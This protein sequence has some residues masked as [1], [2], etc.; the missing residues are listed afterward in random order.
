[1]STEKLF[2]FSKSSET[3]NAS[4]GQLGPYMSAVSFF[5]VIWVL[6][7][8]IINICILFF[9]GCH[10]Q[11]TTTQPWESW[12][13]IWS[14]KIIFHRP[15][16]IY[17]AGSIVSWH[18]NFISLI[19]VEQILEGWRGS[20]NETAWGGASYHAGPKGGS[21]FF[22]VVSHA[23][24]MDSRR[25]CLHFNKFKGCKRTIP[26][27]KVRL[28]SWILMVCTVIWFW[29]VFLIVICNG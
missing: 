16:W 4:T 22:S 3:T 1:M 26:T 2:L 21:D 18:G 7:V 27:N 19:L 10:V 15:M 20:T 12:I 28:H 13:T 23:F 5:L 24:F 29:H 25:Q 14:K 9:E 11:T 8:V 6:H 17:L